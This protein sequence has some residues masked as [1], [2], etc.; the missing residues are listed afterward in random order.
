MDRMAVPT[1]TLLI[2][3]GVDQGK[4]VT[5][6][7]GSVHIGRGPENE[8]RVLDTE[9]SRLHASLEW[10]EGTWLLTDQGSSNGTFV[11]GG[12]VRRKVLDEGDQI[13]IGRTVLSFSESPQEDEAPAVN[14][15]INLVEADASDRSSIVGTISAA[16]AHKL[17]QRAAVS[18]LSRIGVT[19]ASLQTLYRISEE[20]VRPSLPLDT[21]LQRI[22]DLTIQAVGADRGCMLV[23]DT[24]SDRIVPRIV[25]TRTG[26]LSRERMPVSTSIVN[27]VIAKGEGV[28]TS[29][30]R[31]D[32]RFDPGQSILQAG[33][34]EALCVPM[35]GRYELMGV[36]YVDTTTPGHELEGA[37]GHRFSDEL[38][39]LLVAIGRQS[40]L[41]V[42]N[43]RYQQ[44]LVEAERLAAMGQTIALLSHHIKNILQGVRGGSY[45]IDRGLKDSQEDLIRKG[46]D[47][48]ERNQDRIYTLVMD[49]LT[50][51]KER[52]PQLEDSQLNTVVGEVCDLIDARLVDSPTVLVR[53]F[54]VDLPISR[55]DIEGIH[56]AVLNITGNAVDA[57]DRQDDGRIVVETGHD[58]GRDLLYVQVTDNG[59]GIPHEERE[60][61]FNLFASNKG[62]RGTGL[63]LAVSQKILREHGGDIR[64]DCPPAGGCMFRLEWPLVHSGADVPSA[65]VRSTSESA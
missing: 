22:L 44:A 19:N 36:I 20:A 59:P 54:A 34:R 50:F 57:L 26:I 13:Q 46:W 51:S 32:T 11:N 4:R 5:I 60:Q 53:Q 23:S 64:V 58:T 6:E 65:P 31:H 61:V 38:L 8:V 2:L 10:H 12:A 41:A 24:R 52:Q 45:L 1:A 15:L 9:V 56:R 49:M 18:P 55:F 21:L 39:A 30:A 29:D 42:E 17:T 27:Y 28:W 14:D 3:Q 37:A 62:S 25:R 40:A 47:I 63:G 48:V 7:R 16:Q 35:Q 43:N 33:I